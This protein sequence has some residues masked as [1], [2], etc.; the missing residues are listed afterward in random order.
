MIFLESL[1]NGEQDEKKISESDLLF[2]SNS[3]LKSGTFGSWPR[4]QKPRNERRQE[5]EHAK[6]PKSF[7]VVYIQEL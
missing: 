6:W 7:S 1:F 5:E 4:K 2:A 3:L